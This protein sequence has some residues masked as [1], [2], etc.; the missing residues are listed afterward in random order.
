MTC[1]FGRN[2]RITLLGESHGKC[3]GITADGLPAGMP[4]DMEAMEKCMEKRKA[5]GDISTARREE[6]K[7]VILSGVYQG[8]TDGTPLT[9]IIENK[10]MHSQDYNELIFRPSHADY[11][12]YI[13]LGSFGDYRGGGSFSGRMTAPIVALGSVLSKALES[14]GV[15][16]GSHISRCG[17]ISDEDFPECSE[18]ELNDIFKTLAEKRF[19][20]ID[21][22]RGEEMQELI[23]EAREDGD[24]VGGVLETAITGL[25]VGVGSPF[26]DSLES[27]LAHLVFSVP[28]VKGIEF[29]LGFGFAY[30][31]GS[32]AN[33]QWVVEDGRIMTKSNM[34]GGINGGISNGMPVIFRTVFR[35]T[36]SISK[37][38]QTVDIKTLEEKPLELKGRHDPAI[39]H[40]ALAVIDSVTAI[41]IFDL[42]LERSRDVWKGSF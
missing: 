20:V 7:P 40:R 5:W 32:E 39:F 11:T 23:R 1:T 21:D 27:V 28:G 36:P 22:G 12:S 8:K 3:V 34:S 17:E 19:A 14:T 10:Q 16:I 29:G 6:D 30:L 9:I 18:E 38:Q 24:S 4:V 15:T 41:G 37:P 42:M 31:G 13:K 2:I 26:F 33:D 35:P 25:P